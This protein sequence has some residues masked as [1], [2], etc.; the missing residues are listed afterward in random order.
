VPG[1]RDRRAQL[2]AEDI[3]AAARPVR[4]GKVFPLG[5][6][7][8]QN[9]PQAG[10]WGGRR[11]PIGSMLATGTDASAGRPD[12]TPRLN[13]TGGTGSPINPLA[14]KSELGEGTR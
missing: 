12:G 6:A 8:D 7:L 9:E 5:L 11:N 4:R 2:Q 14:I 3:V 13:R 10:V 1:R